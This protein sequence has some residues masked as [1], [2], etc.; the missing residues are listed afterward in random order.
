MYSLQILEKL[1]EELKKKCKTSISN[2]LPRKSKK[3]F[4]ANTLLEK[5]LKQSYKKTELLTK[6]LAIADKTI[7]ELSEPLREL[8]N[9][10]KS[11]NKKSRKN[12]N[13]NI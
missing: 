5:K 9:G 8:I 1:I 13:L 6:E 2:S 3:T 4:H 10:V 7:E 11:L 12:K